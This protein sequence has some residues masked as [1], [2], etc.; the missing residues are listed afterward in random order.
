MA[1]ASIPAPRELRGAGTPRDVGVQQEVQDKIEYAKSLH[2]GALERMSEWEKLYKGEYDTPKD[3][4]DASLHAY[5]PM[6]PRAI[7]HKML[8]LLSL[9]AKMKNQVVPK[10]DTQ[11]EEAICTRLERYLDGYQWRIQSEKNEA[12]FRHAVQWGLLRGK[13]ALIAQYVP[14]FVDSE[15]FPIRSIAPDPMTVFEVPGENGVMYFVRESKRYAMELK[16]EID[17][18]SEWNKAGKDVWTKPIKFS[19]KKKTDA[20]KLTEYYDGEYYAV[21][22]D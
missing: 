22:I 7:V 9:R 1:K 10:K 14:R 5:K 3:I 8:A 11:E 12:V 4:A 15:Y 2:A 6:R 21:L 16:K 17:K 20:V 13:T 19:D 18:A